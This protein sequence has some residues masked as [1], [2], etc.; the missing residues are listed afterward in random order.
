MKSTAQIRADISSEALSV[1]VDKFRIVVLQASKNL[2]ATYTEAF[3]RDE[4]KRCEARYKLQK[5]RLEFLKLPVIGS[6]NKSAK[7]SVSEV[8]GFVKK[9]QFRITVLNYILQ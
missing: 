6:N 2:V 1:P 7:E 4:L 8:A 5:E 3:L 9:E